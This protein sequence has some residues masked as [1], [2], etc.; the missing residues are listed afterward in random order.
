MNTLK[1]RGHSLLGSCLLVGLLIPTFSSAEPVDLESTKNLPAWTELASTCTIDEDSIANF[2]TFGPNLL[3]KKDKQS[4]IQPIHQPPPEEWPTKKF[5][6]KSLNSNTFDS[7]WITYKQLKARCNVQN[8]LDNAELETTIRNANGIGFKPVTGEKS[9]PDWDALIVGYVDPDGQETIHQIRATLHQ[10]HRQSGLTSIVAA[11]DSNQES[12]ASWDT[13]AKPR[14]RMVRFIHNWDFGR[15][16]YYVEISILR[17]SLKKNP[18]VYSL[19]LTTGPTII[20]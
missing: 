1:S 3:Y 4:T 15:N 2:S 20:H 8:H 16:A 10:V 11:F 12:I 7:K 13:P 5:F 19:R 17:K 6:N 18:R 14:E 9:N